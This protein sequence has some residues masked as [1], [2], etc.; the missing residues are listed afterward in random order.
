MHMRD[1]FSLYTQTGVRVSV[2]KDCIHCYKADTVRLI[3][4]LR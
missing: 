4:L 1:S 3:F 2:L